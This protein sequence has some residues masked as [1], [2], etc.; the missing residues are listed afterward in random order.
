M[1]SDNPHRYTG[2]KRKFTEAED[3]AILAHSRGEFGMKTLVNITRSSYLTLS[4]R[5]K[6]LGV[7]IKRTRIP[8]EKLY[9]GR[10]KKPAKYD[11]VKGGGEQFVLTVY[12]EGR[13]RLLEE[14]IKHHGPFKDKLS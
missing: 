1:Q 8:A 3:Q 14:L 13:D 12:T 7:S 9:N 10:Y 6:E 4:K 5:A 11:I 2:I